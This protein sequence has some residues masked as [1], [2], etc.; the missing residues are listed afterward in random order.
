MFN[1]LQY[2]YAIKE[3]YMGGR[4]VCHG[5]ADTCDILDPNRPRMLLCRC[6][7]NTCGSYKR[8]D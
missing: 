6:A 1:T 7:H 3:I 2:F 4:C 8:F 5:H